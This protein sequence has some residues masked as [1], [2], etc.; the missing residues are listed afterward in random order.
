MTAYSIHFVSPFPLFQY[1]VP[2]PGRRSEAEPL[3]PDVIREHT[4]PLGIGIALRV[5]IRRR[6]ELR[7]G[8]GDQISKSLGRLW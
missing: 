3:A 6:N 1:I 2:I 7:I 5:G 8:A 4:K